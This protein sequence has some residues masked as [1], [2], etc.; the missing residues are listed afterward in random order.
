VR[1]G[2]TWDLGS[3]LLVFA[4]FLAVEIPLA[5]IVVRGTRRLQ[6]LIAP[7]VLLLLAAVLPNLTAKA[8]LLLGS[9][10]LMFALAIGTRAKKT[11]LEDERLLATQGPSPWLSQ[12]RGCALALV[13]SGAAMMLA[14]LV[15]EGMHARLLAVS[16]FGPGSLLVGLG[17]LR[18]HTVLVAYFGR[19]RARRLEAVQIGTGVV[20]YGLVLAG[21]LSPD[22]NVRLVLWTLSFVPFAVHFTV[23]WLPLARAQER[24][25]LP[26]TAL[27]G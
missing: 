4:I 17:L 10:F 8:L 20:A 9:L 11:R 24:P 14:G 6:S 16:L 22:P 13:A 1:H 15:A 7:A 18:R 3:A 26:Q 25:A 27:P 21:D 2:Q 23:I 12:S 5:I 19:S